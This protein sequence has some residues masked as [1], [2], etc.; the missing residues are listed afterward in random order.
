MAGTISVSE[1][2]WRARQILNDSGATRWQD[3]ELVDWLNDAHRAVVV[4]LPNANAQVADLVLT[5]GVEQTL[6]AGGLRLLDVF[7]NANGYPVRM[8][9][10]N[11]L[12]ELVPTWRSANTGAAAEMVAY[13]PNLPKVFW[14]YPIPQDGDTLTV[15]YSAIPTRIA[16][17]PPAQPGG[18]PGY[19]P[20]VIQLDDEYEEALLDYLLYRAFNKESEH[21]G[22]AS[23]SAVHYK[24][25]INALIPFGGGGNG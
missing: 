1:L 19:S 10:R 14:V 4:R 22:D 2:L 7:A 11:A 8:I 6:P 12:D 15:S 5:A 25:F 23:P 24:A 20:G 16:Y 13:D 17:T 18:A 21:T 3:S 9:E